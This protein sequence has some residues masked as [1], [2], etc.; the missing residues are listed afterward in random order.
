MYAFKHSGRMGDLL[1]SLYYA[2]QLANNEPFKLVLQ[3]GVAMWD[4]SGR[5]F[6]MNRADAEFVRPLLEAQSY[7]DSVEITDEPATDCFRLDEFRNHMK[8]LAGKEI[9]QWYY[10]FSTVKLEPAGFGRPVLAVPDVPKTDKVAVCFTPR[11]KSAASGR[12]LNRIAD[13]VVF[14]GLPEEHETFCKKCFPVPYHPVKNALEMLEFAASCR[15][16]IG[17]VSGVFAIMECAKIPRI[18]FKK[19]S[20]NDVEPAGC[21]HYS[22][23]S[24]LDIAYTLENLFK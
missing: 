23:R 2:K 12:M 4:P 1:Y 21:E 19:V 22:V 3:T 8:R 6:L 17:N 13:K 24:S 16:F 7:I 14:I 18:L 15:M 10:D 11:Y 5:P 20:G 9:R